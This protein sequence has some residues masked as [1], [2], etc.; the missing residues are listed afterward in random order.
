MVRLADFPGWEREHLL[1]KT[2]DLTGFEDRPWQRPPPLER[3]RVA[4]VT[5]AGL[6]RKGDAAF[7]CDDVRAC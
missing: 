5:T 4:I 6:H 1:A 7:V 2:R 3:C